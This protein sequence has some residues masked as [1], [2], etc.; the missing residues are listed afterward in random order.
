MIHSHEAN[1]QFVNFTVT[2]DEF[3]ETLDMLKHEV[4]QMKMKFEEQNHGYI[5][6]EANMAFR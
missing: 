6:T 4:I 3:K 1:R 2:Q 5:N